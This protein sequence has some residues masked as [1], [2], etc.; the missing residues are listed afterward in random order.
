MI[1]SLILCSLLVFNSCSANLEALLIKSGV[2]L[3]ECWDE[4]PIKIIAIISIGVWCVWYIKHYIYFKLASD[5][6]DACKKNDTER[7]I[8]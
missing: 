1:K 3:L 4:Q 8:Q 7:A 6:I 5:L 2:A